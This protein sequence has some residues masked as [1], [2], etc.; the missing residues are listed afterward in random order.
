MICV[1]VLDLGPH[2]YVQYCQ[3]TLIFVPAKISWSIGGKVLLTVEFIAKWDRN[4]KSVVTVVLT[5]VLQYQSQK[6]AHQNVQK[7]VH[8]QMIMHSM[9]MEI[10]FQYQDAL[11]YQMRHFIRL[12]P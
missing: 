1:H 11:A 3:A 10:V 8:A 4:T 9:N 12:V 7:V 2:V 6:T 5:L